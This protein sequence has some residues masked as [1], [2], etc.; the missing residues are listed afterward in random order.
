M[1]ILLSHILSKCTPTDISS[2]TDKIRQA[3]R[4]ASCEPVHEQ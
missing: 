3:F 4:T 1:Q 2:E